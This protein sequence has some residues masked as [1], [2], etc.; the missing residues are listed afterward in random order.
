MSISTEHSLGLDPAHELPP[1][2]E[3]RRSFIE[4]PADVPN[5]VRSNT[6]AVLGAKATPSLLTARAF[7]NSLK[8]A[9]E[10]VRLDDL[11]IGD[12]SPPV[13]EKMRVDFAMAW[14]S[15][16]VRDNLRGLL[17]EVIFPS[18]LQREMYESMSQLKQVHAQDIDLHNESFQVFQ[19]RERNE[20]LVESRERSTNLMPFMEFDLVY[21]ISSSGEYVAFDPTCKFRNN[22]QTEKRTK[23]L[24]TIA[25]LL[26]RNIVLIDVVLKDSHFVWS[27][28]SDHIHR[29]HLPCTVDFDDV[30]R[31]IIPRKLWGRTID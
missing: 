2:P 18:L 31:Q 23:K 3:H 20:V 21:R 17:P 30:I 24:S 5:A 11:Q 10:S 7:A 15:P 9:A 8:L 29:W 28:V 12:I 16:K 14:E 6:A 27:T 25:A 13:L 22:F 19:G 4:V 1:S 26:E